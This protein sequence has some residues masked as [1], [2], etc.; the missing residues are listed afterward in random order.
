MISSAFKSAYVNQ[1]GAQNK[2]INTITAG[3]KDAVALMG[4]I[5]GVSG[6]FGEVGATASKHWLANKVGGVGGNI[7]L[8]SMKEKEQN[9]KDNKQAE[10]MISKEEVTKTLKSNLEG[11]PI[12]NPALKTL[13]TVFEKLSQAKEDGVINKQGNIESSLGNIDPN[14]ELGKK[15]MKE[16]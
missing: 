6:A 1:V 3:A 10:N 13:S 9:I 16:M 4:A 11:N 7:M 12:N 8:A 2:G 14:S 15:I 5:A